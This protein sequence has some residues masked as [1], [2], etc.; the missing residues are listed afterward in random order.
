MRRAL[1]IVG[2]A[3]AL[4]VLVASTSL[5]Y[6]YGYRWTAG[7]AALSG[8]I[9][10]AVGYEYLL[11]HPLAQQLKALSSLVAAWRDQDFSTSITKPENADLNELTQTL[12]SLGDTLRSERVNLV[13]RELMLDTLIQNTPTA[14]VLVGTNQRVA[15]CNLAARELFN[16]G[17]RFEGESWIDV[18]ARLPQTLRE[19]L[20]NQHEGLVTLEQAGTDAVD[21]EEIFHLSQ[22]QFTLQARPHRLILLRRMTTELARQEVATWKKV[23]R[24]I[25]HELNN[26]LA[27]ISSMAHSGAVLLARGQLEP[28]PKVFATISERSTHLA[29]FIA[30]YARVAK[31]PLPQRSAVHWPSLLERVIATGAGVI[32][33]CP[34]AHGDIDVVQIEQLLINLVKNA[35]EAGSDP[36]QINLSVHASSIGTQ[37][38][39][40]LEVADRGSGMSEM[41]MT[42]ALLPFYSTKRTPTDGSGSGLG[43]ALAREIAEA[44]GGRISLSNRYGGG[45]VVRVFLPGGSKATASPLVAN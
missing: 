12:N 24:V 30:S 1:H 18:I 45:L 26:S 42:S 8:A 35:V 14:L 9:A 38:G 23:I 36:K 19:A 13:Q 17:K 7:L 6:G 10:L 27:P 15:V 3:L 28:L 22:R 43:L 40:N 39:F 32:T 2:F 31:L 16:A 44:H 37:S 4:L 41:V 20:S 33:S 11:W 5:L 29:Q 34:D 21:S 25:S